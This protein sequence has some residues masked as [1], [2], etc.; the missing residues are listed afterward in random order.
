[1]GPVVTAESLILPILAPV[2]SYLGTIA[3]ALLG[4]AMLHMIG[5]SN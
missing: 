2:V 5:K 3:V 1:L 4:M